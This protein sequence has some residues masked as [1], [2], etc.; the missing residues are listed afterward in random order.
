MSET[1]RALWDDPTVVAAMENLEGTLWAAPDDDYRT[2]V[3]RRYVAALAQAIRSAIVA[4]QDGIAEEDLN[5]DVIWGSSDQC[6]SCL[7]DAEDFQF[8]ELVIAE[9]VRLAF[10]ELDLCVSSFQRTS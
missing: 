5:V 4:R 7:M 2:W 1:I 9:A 6:V 3:K 8:E 10:H